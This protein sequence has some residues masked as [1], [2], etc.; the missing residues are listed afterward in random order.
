MLVTTILGEK[1]E[2]Q[3]RRLKVTMKTRLTEPNW[4]WVNRVIFHLQ[5]ISKNNISII[6]WQVINVNAWHFVSW[7]K[8]PSQTF[9]F[10]TSLPLQPQLPTA[11]KT[12]PMGDLFHAWSREIGVGPA[13]S[14]RED[15]PT[16]QQET[17]YHLYHQQS[18]FHLYL[19]S[20]SDLKVLM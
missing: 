9:H 7:D 3:T 16:R 15:P 2:G 19:H 20:L 5:Y 12:F 17:S 11:G 13:K 4:I 10:M 6:S 14:W 1:I 18:Q 8:T